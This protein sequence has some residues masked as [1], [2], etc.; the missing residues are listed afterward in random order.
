VT[1]LSRW[2]CGLAMIVGPAS[3]ADELAQGKKLFTEATVP[4]CALCHSLEAAG[5][6]GTVGPPLD[7]LKPDATRVA[8]ALRNGIGSMPSYKDTLSEQQILLLARYVAKASGG[9]K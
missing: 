8:T 2:V 3:A 6:T 1:L 7:E 4:A 5:A 9:E